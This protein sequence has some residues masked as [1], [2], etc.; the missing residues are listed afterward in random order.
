MN[1]RC[2]SFDDL[3][4]PIW[5]SWMMEEWEIQMESREAGSDLISLKLKLWPE[6]TV[7]CITIS[8]WRTEKTTQNE[9]EPHNLKTTLPLHLTTARTLSSDF[10]N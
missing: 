2:V 1:Q 6:A 10:C 9:V 7:G 3:A 5:F 4:G 8:I